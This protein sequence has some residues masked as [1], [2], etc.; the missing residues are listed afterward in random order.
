MKV[1]GP[2]KR[3][4]GREHVVLV[5]PDGKTTSISYPKYLIES[6][7][8][9]PLAKNET[10]HHKDGNPLN[11]AFDNLQIID[12]IQHAVADVKRNKPQKVKCVW[13]GKAFILEGGKLSDAKANRKQGKTG[14]FCS[15]RCSGQYGAEV[16]NN[17]CDKIAIVEVVTELI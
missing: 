16:Q 1:Y 8:G 9:R 11:N 3:K 7:L 4:D 15:R 2:Y 13:C 6:A 10:V 5:Y 12:R 17:R 14:P